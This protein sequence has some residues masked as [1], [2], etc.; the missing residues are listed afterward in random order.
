MFFECEFKNGK[1]LFECKFKRE[2]AF[3]N[4]FSNV[5]VVTTRGGESSYIILLNGH[6]GERSHYKT[7]INICPY[8]F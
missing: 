2:N 3:S 8:I 6:T 4:V 5:D 1:C 7:K